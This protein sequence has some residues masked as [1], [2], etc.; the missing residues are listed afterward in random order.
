MAPVMAA[1]RTTPLFSLSSGGQRLAG[2]RQCVEH[3]ARQWQ[4]LAARPGH[5]QATGVAVEQADVDQL[6]Q[7][8]EALGHGRLAQ[9]QSVSAA[10]HARELTQLDE[11][12]QMTKASLGLEPVEQHG[13]REGLSW[14]LGH[15]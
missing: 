9:A 1:T 5:A 15:G 4:Q 8:G 10:A 11:H 3:A 2:L 13:G 14:R 7:V 6:L 12:L